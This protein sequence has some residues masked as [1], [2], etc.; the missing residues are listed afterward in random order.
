MRDGKFWLNG[1]TYFQRLI[2]DQGYFPG[3]LL[4]AR[5][6]PT[7]AATSSSPSHSFQRARA[8]TR[9]SR[10]PGGFYWADKLGFLVWEEM[11]SFHQHSARGRAQACG[12]EWE[13]AVMRDRGHACIVAWVPMNESFGLES[14]QPEVAARFLDGLYHF[15][16]DIDGT[17]PVI[18]NDGW[19]TRKR[20]CA[21]CTTTTQV[22]R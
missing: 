11:P 18:S 2:L 15:T 7:C 10:T 14:V 9:R 8:S 1:E 12:P 4:T 13:Q 5:A 16:H 22:T 19:S 3:G 20:T 21:R 17:R 6:T